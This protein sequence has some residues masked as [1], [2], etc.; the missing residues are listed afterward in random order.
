MDL[1]DYSKTM[2]LWLPSWPAPESIRRMFSEGIRRYAYRVLRG[3]RHPRLTWSDTELIAD[4]DTQ[5]AVWRLGRNGWRSHCTCGFPNGRCAHAYAAALLFQ[6][7]LKRENWLH[8]GGRP[9]AGRPGRA[10]RKGT[11]GKRR[12]RPLDL[13]QMDLFNQA[14]SGPDSIP[15]RIEA[16]VDFHHEPDRVTLRFYLTEEGRRSILR[17]QALTNLALRVR[18]SSRAERKFSE[19]DREFLAWLS[20]ELRDRR[21]VQANLTVLKLKESE[22]RYWLE[23]WRQQPNR[24]FDRDGQKRIALGRR[25][26]EI[27]FRL[28]RRRRYLQVEAII[29]GPKGGAYPLHTVLEQFAAGHGRLMLEGELTD[30]DSPIPREELFERFGGGPWLIPWGEI[31]QRLPAGIHRRFDLLDGEIIQRYEQRGRMGI[32]VAPDEAWVRITPLISGTP[33]RDGRGAVKLRIEKNRLG[34]ISLIAPELPRVLRRLSSFPGIES[35]GAGNFRLPLTAEAISALHEWYH[36]TSPRIAW[37]IAPDLSPLLVDGPA[38]LQ[39][40]LRVLDRGTYVETCV[41]W[42][43]KDGAGPT[44]DDVRRALRSNAPFV[45][46]GRNWFALDPEATSIALAELAAAGVDPFGVTRLLRPELRKVLD[47][48][49]QTPA[50][51]ADGAPLPAELRAGPALDELEM[52]PEIAGILRPYQV[53]GF[54][55]LAERL[56][57]GVGAILAD[58]MGLGKTLQ[59]LAALAALRN[60]EREARPQSAGEPDGA[61]APAG[62][63]VVCPASVVSVWADHVQRFFPGLTAALYTGPPARRRSLL[64]TSDW[65]VLVVNYALIR[66]DIDFFR[67]RRFSVVVLDEAQQIKNPDA[68]VTR[69]VKT[70]RSPRRLALTG[71]PLENRLLDLWSIMDFLN[72]GYLGNAREFLDR[73]GN[74]ERGRLARRLA[75]V[76]L[77][78]T[79]EE[80]APELPPRTE[81]V[82]RIELEPEQQT[83]YDKE[84]AR[85]RRGIREKGPMQVLAALTRMRQICCHPALVD[86]AAESLPSAKLD[87]LAAMLEEL[88]AEGHSALVFSQFTR[89]LARIQTRLESLNIPTLTLIGDTPPDRR[90]ALVE[91]FNQAS[92]PTVFLL[93]LRAAGTGLNL[94]RAEYV[95]LYDPWWNPAVE[96]QAID[97]AHRIGQKRPVFA[98]R[99][100]TRGTVEEKVLELQQEKAELFRDVIDSAAAARVPAGLSAAE[101]AALLE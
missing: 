3:L 90:G 95:F 69:A 44:T 43:D 5:K 1:P 77:R 80:V 21:E 98:Y 92:E 81:E 60:R 65:D 59:V 78:R 17:M 93:S 58:D 94:T 82:L 8:R 72:H 46:T 41:V 89:M 97:R 52:P 35:A 6:E 96:S 36:E 50:V 15:A 74:A 76:L 85:A 18:H 33:V 73:F 31:S 4:L 39:P 56:R 61:A 99:L 28:G 13:R 19:A 38:V 37:E 67:N 42:R 83:F 25:A 88:V 100:V 63:L 68:Q 84:L 11:A 26:A 86:E 7:I 24:F 16:E 29:I 54:R 48:A 22:F 34:V 27:R 62:A 91:Q 71:T 75:P 64:E 79:K 20:G 55:F 9:T 70:L 47:A 101:L 10:P 2:P 30:F 53:A 51:G 32:R 14:L 45:Q 66:N 40:E 57:W 23:R 12:S 87:T 49:K